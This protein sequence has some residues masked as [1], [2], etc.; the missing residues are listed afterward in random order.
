MIEVTIAST[1]EVDLKDKFELHRDIVRVAEY[2][3]FDPRGEYLSPALQGYR[4]TSGEY[5]P[6]E[7]GS[8]RRPSVELGLELEDGRG[9]LR[10]FD[11]ANNRFL[12]TPKEAQ[13]ARVRTAEAERDAAEAKVDRLAQEVDPSAGK[14][15]IVEGSN[16]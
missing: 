3:L 2:S 4:L 11:P 13:E 10:F 7:P 14:S 12:L 16:A 6:I 15:A 5:A 9:A 1:R 8:G